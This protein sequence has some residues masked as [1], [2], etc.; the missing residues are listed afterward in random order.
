[1]QPAVKQ[2]VRDIQ[3]SL[4]QTTTTAKQLASGTGRTKR[5]LQNSR[6]SD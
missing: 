1:M 2:G 4:A 5:F 3:D 6:T